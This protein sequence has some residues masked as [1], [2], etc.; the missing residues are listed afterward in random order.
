MRR[1]FARVSSPKPSVSSSLGELASPFVDI[2]TLGNLKFH[3]VFEPRTRNAAIRLCG[4]VEGNP[5][6]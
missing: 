3:A 2:R 1:F 6:K 4:I 5:K